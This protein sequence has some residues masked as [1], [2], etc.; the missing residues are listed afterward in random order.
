MTILRYARPQLKQ[1]VLQGKTPGNWGDSPHQ[2]Y[3]VCVALSLPPWV[4]PEDLQPFVNLQRYFTRVTGVQYSID[5]IVPVQ[6]PRVCGLTVPENLQVIP[7]K[8]N[9]VKGNYWEGD[10]P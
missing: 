8:E 4:R 5:H 10:W 7:E 9:Q 6:H 2:V 3:R 1:L